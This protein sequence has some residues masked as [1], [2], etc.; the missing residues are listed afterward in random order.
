MDAE[1]PEESEGEKE[2]ET[3]PT[4]KAKAEAKQT[5]R[6]SS[7]KQEPVPPLYEMLSQAEKRA[8]QVEID[9]LCDEDLEKVT[10]VKQK[11]LASRDIPG[12]S[13]E[14]DLSQLK[15]YNK[16]FVSYRVT[17]LFARFFLF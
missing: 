9:K 4:F 10:V 7:Q 5:A 17:D 15:R 12:Q 11:S 1:S 13:L 16:F 6:E 3:R 14:H 2:E 8:L